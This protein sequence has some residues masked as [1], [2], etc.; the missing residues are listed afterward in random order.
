MYTVTINTCYCLQLFVI[1][2]LFVHFMVAE[3]LHVFFVWLWIFVCHSVS[4][5]VSAE[6]LSTL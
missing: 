5:I 1:V 2:S 6:S 4:C 3:H